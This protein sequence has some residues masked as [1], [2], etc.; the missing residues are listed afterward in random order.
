[1]L[2][3]PDENSLGYGFL[4]FIVGVS[5]LL[6]YLLWP[7]FVFISDAIPGLLGIY[8]FAVLKFFVFCTVCVVFYYP[9][10]WLAERLKHERNR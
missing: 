9:A 6:T 2:K 7:A 8:A 1:M 3:Q 5:F 4:L 10:V